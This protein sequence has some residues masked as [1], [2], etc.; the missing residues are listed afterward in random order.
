[1]ATMRSERLAT[2]TPELDAAEE[3]W[4]DRFS[5]V[6]ERL[7]TLHRDTAG[8]LRG[9]YLSAAARYL[10]AGSRDGEARLLDLG[11]GSGYT[12]RFMAG[13]STRVL[14]IDLSPAQIELAR[15]ASAAD[16]NRDRLEFRVSGVADLRDE[17]PFDA[18]LGHAFL[19]HLARD[20]LEL[21]LDDIAAVLRPGGR[22]WFLEPVFFPQGDV[23]AAARLKQ[24]EWMLSGAMGRVLALAGVVDGEPLKDSESFFA[25]ADRAG[26]FLSPKEV[27]FRPEEL[28]DV[29]GGRLQIESL[30]WV[31]TASYTT[32]QWVSLVR[33][34]RLRRLLS[35]TLVAWSAAFDM[36]TG[37]G[38]G[39]GVYRGLPGYGFAAIA[40][41]AAS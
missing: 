10:A 22:A 37:D 9:P 34:P 18:V 40:C 27:P 15:E 31:N 3:A 4:W 21:L 20:E 25:E 33:R 16:P 12:S 11:C 7:W 39:L 1:M 28:Q 29:F 14:G 2:S 26:W 35:S 23:T 38:D 6:S 32:A 24:A 17:D 5:P 13:P 36:R 19:H 8:A 30:A 41:R